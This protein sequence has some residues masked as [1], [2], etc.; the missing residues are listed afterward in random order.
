EHGHARLQSSPRTGRPKAG[1]HDLRIHHDVLRLLLRRGASVSTDHHAEAEQAGQSLAEFLT[2][3]DGE[4]GGRLRVVAVANSAGD[5]G[6]CQNAAVT[7]MTTDVLA[8]ARVQVL[9]DGVGLGE[10]DLLRCL[11]LP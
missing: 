2:G 4:T 11:T 3:V 7:E 6:G 1:I 10:A 9:G 5:V 8:L